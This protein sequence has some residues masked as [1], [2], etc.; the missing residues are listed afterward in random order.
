MKQLL[1]F[2]GI[3][4][5]ILAILAVIGRLFF[6]DIGRTDNYSMV[7]TIVP[8]DIFLFRTVGLLGT[9]DVAVCHNPEDPAVLVVGRIIGVPG[10]NIFI[11]DNHIN[12]NGR[13]IHHNYVEPVMYFDT[14]TEEQMKYVVRQAEEKVGGT[15]FT[16]AFMDTTRGKNFDEVVVPQ[17]SFFLLGDNRNMAYDSRNYGMVPI[18]SCIGE[19]MF[20]LWGAESNGDLLQSSRSIS[21]IK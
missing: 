21:W 6:F 4:L 18:S 19:A 7:P 9:G 5:V 17:D 10:D 15:L 1:K 20:L 2:I 3:V 8:G 12:L 11:R 13:V 16:V 14:T